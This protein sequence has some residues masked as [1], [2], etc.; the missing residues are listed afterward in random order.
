MYRKVLSR[1]S[2]LLAAVVALPLLASGSRA[3]E[4]GDD[5]EPSSPLPIRFVVVTTF[6]TGTD[7][8]GPGEFNT[9]VVNYPLP[10]VI[11]F[12]QGYHHLRYN[13]EKTGAGH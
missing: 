1:C 12:P 2:L 13:P 3:E 10:K 8:S 9:W 4:P 7:T 5:F 11:P 6:D